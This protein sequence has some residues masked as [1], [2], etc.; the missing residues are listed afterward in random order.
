MALVIGNRA[1][2]YGDLAQADNFDGLACAPTSVANALLA[3]GVDELLQMPSEPGTWQSLYQTRNKLAEDYFYTSEN[4]ARADSLN[5][6]L[7]STRFHIADGSL[8]SMILSGT[9]KYIADRES[10]LQY[11]TPVTVSASGLTQG[12]ITY[13]NKD[14]PV[15]M[16]FTGFDVVGNIDGTRVQTPSQQQYERYFTEISQDNPLASRGVLDYLMQGLLRGPVVFGMYYTHKIGGHAIMATDIMINDANANGILERGEATI[17]FIDPLNPST[18]YSPNVGSPATADQFNRIQSTGSPYFTTGDIW[19]DAD[20]YLAFSYNQRSLALD[21]Q[22]GPNQTIDL[23]P[24]DS[25]NGS[26][27]ERLG[28][29]DITLAMSLNT[30][31]LAPDFDRRAGA[32]SAQTPGLIDFSF[33]LD[34]PVT[35]SQT[36]TGFAYS[37]ESSAYSNYFIYY[38]ALDASGA[39]ETRDTVTGQLVRLVPGDIGYNDAAWVL[40]QE[41]CDGS[42]AATLGSRQSTDQ[43]TL[44]SFELDLSLL[45]TGY[46]VPVARTSGGDVWTPFAA[47]NVDREQHFQSTGPLSWRMEDLRGLGD[48]SFNDL[49]VSLLIESIA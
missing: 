21:P 7:P 12:T 39:I 35:R 6:A 16:N 49:H 23:P 22:N 43:E 10:E 37:N 32:L 27:G 48:R 28:K 14:K 24:G 17:T 4:W 38:E 26:I 19:Q 13:A 29:V 8:P 18:S 2:R 1:R 5:P 11:S 20:G 30:S 33:L 25:S 9:M 3:L 46:L 45:A 31:R 36:L 47:A 41:F 15:P 34:D 44:T 42:G 40:A